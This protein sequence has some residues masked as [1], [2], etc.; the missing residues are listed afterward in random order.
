MKTDYTERLKKWLEE[1]E[2]KRLVLKASWKGFFCD[3]R[4]NCPELK[5]WMICSKCINEP[6]VE[7]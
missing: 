5:Q 1:S 4:D 2:K 7:Q 6:M 3:W